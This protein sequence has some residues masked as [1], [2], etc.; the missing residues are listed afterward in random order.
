[1]A[2]DLPFVQLSSVDVFEH[3]L[4]VHSWIPRFGRHIKLLHLSQTAS[5]GWL[6]RYY[7]ISSTSLTIDRMH[8]TLPSG[9]PL[10]SHS[11]E[12]AK[13][14]IFWGVEDEQRFEPIDASIFFFGCLSF[15]FLSLL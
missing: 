15:G 4:E 11:F 14:V 7:F 3:F 13:G 10:L 12:R 5:L 6:L 2:L 9:L 8:T 1:M